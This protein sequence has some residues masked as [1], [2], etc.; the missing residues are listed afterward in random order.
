[1][2]VIRESYLINAYFKLNRESLAEYH[3]LAHKHNRDSWG[4]LVNGTTST[5]KKEEDAREFI[6]E[7]K[8]T[9]ADRF[10]LMRESLESLPL[11]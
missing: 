1:M 7:A 8:G 2:A 11:Q 6:K 5:F 3:R 9:L 4:S 10:E